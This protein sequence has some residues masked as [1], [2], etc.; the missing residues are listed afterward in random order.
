D[1]IAIELRASTD[2]SAGAAPAPAASA[3]TQPGP[4]DVAPEDEAAF[5]AASANGSAP[6]NAAAPAAKTANAALPPAPAQKPVPVPKA[7]AAGS[8]ASKLKSLAVNGNTIEIQAD[9]A[10]D[11][12]DTQVLSGP[13][14]VVVDLFGAK[15]GIKNAKQS[16]ADGVVSQARIGEHPDKVRV[17]LD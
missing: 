8:T 11:N 2:A 3:P 4:P 17:V 1:E 6:A 9:G 13:D 12:V 7:A 10:I 5:A 16:F 14:R 15:N